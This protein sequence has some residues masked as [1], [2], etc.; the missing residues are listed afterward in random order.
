M[1]EREA[2]PMNN[3]DILN[4]ALQQVK[5]DVE[6]VQSLKL[7]RESQGISQEDVARKTGWPLE[8]VQNI[9]SLETDPTLGEL[10]RFAFAVGAMVCHT[11]ER[12][13]KH[14]E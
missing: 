4:K 12:A 7:A 2:Q 5:S 13:P 1:K 11:L 14:G 6:F 3:R 8:K 9:E 10:R